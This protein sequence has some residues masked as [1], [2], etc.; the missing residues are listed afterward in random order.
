[1]QYRLLPSFDRSNFGVARTGDRH[2]CA[3]MCVYSI[4]YVYC[5]LCVCVCVPIQHANLLII[6]TWESSVSSLLPRAVE[7]NRFLHRSSFI[8]CCERG[9]QGC[10]RTGRMSTTLVECTSIG[11]FGRF[12]AASISCGSYR[13]AREIHWHQ[14][15]GRNRRTRIKA[16]GLKILRNSAL[17]GTYV[18]RSSKLAS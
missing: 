5:R 6:Q 18:R 1:M 7:M 12:P 8:V 10:S 13:P 11:E 17:A 15:L 2:R 9:F 16:A 14:K 3:C 4:Q